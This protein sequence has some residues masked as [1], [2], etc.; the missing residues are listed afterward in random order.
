MRVGIPKE[1]G[2]GDGRVAVIPES[3]KQIKAAGHEVLIEA[4]A[5]A[6]AGHPDAV[7]QEAGASIVPDAA[8]LWSRSEIVLK[9]QPPMQNEALDRHEVDLLTEGA[10][11]VCMLRPLSFLDTVRMLAA[12]K[13]LSFSMD[14]MPRTTRAQRMDALSSM[15]TI[16]GYKAV[17]LAAAASP[18]L[19]P[20]LVTAAGTVAPSRLIVVGVGVAGLQ[21]IATARRLG[22]VV[23]AYDIR[24]AAKEEAESLGATFIGPALEAK[25]T[26]DE[27]G[28]ARALSPEK[29]REGLEKLR[30]RLRMADAVI[31]TARVP[32]KPAPKLIP[33]EV[34][35]EM[36]PGAVL[37]DLAADMGGNCEL[38]KAGE[39]V[40][41]H[42]VTILGPVR[43][44]ST[45]PFH[46]SQM[47]SKNVTAFFLHITKDGKLNLDW[48]DDITSGTCV[49]R[50]GQIVNDATRARIEETSPAAA[51]PAGRS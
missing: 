26:Q 45:V 19:F 48:S 23:E 25:D 50:D 17:L 32:G 28:Y 9:I 34:V 22:A 21:A 12:R 10:A 2:R 46:A 3:V 4:G 38:T 1:V 16:A 20:M 51:G 33:A 13:I 43:L 14:M 7:Y 36:K 44:A 27:Q 47:Y 35:G 29:Q 6:G 11:L 31:T 24:P 49:T 39:E 41:R 40:H 18:R 30:A 42:G 15:S 37:V 8:D 5:G